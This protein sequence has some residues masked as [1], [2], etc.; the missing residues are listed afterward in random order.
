MSFWLRAFWLDAA[1]SSYPCLSMFSTS[2]GSEPVA[3]GF[4]RKPIMVLT[5]LAC[6]LW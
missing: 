5:R 4:V 3:K 6:P 1:K 2:C